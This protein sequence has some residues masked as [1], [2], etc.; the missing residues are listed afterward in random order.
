MLTEKIKRSEAL[1]LLKTLHGGN[2][3]VGVTATTTERMNKTD[4]P[5][6]GKVKKTASMSGCLLHDYESN[7]NAQRV[8][9]GKAADFVAQASKWGKRLGNT[10]LIVHTPKG[11]TVE[12]HYLDLRVLRVTQKPRLFL[13]GKRISKKL[14]EPWKTKRNDSPKQ[15]LKKEIV[16][17]RYTFDNIRRINLAFRDAHGKVTSKRRLVIVDDK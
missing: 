1:E 14:I 10:C 9:E 6:W 15:N 11:E 3:F 8:R 2:T 12:K 7:V 4:N 16:I 17:R 13:D 5:Y